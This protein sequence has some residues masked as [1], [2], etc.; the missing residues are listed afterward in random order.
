MRASLFSV[1]SIA[2]VISAY[3]LGG[4]VPTRIASPLD[5]KFLEELLS[6]MSSSMLVIA[7]FSLGT[8][9]TAYT[10]VSNSASPRASPVLVEGDFAQNAISTFIGVFLFS[11]IAQVALGSNVY[12]TGGRA[13]LFLTSLVLLLVSVATLINWID[14]LSR[15]GQ[16]R[17]TLKTLEQCTRTAI[18]ARAREPSFGGREF[19]SLPDGHDIC[20]K[21]F[22]YVQSVNFEAIEKVVDTQEGKFYLLAEPGT[23][24]HLHRPLGRLV[25]PYQGV[26][27][28]VADEVAEAFTVGDARTTLQDARFGL[29][30]IGEAAS[31][32]LSPGINDP[33]TA[34]DSAVTASRAICAW[35]EETLGADRELKRPWLYA[36]PLNITE[37]LDCAYAPIARYGS[38]Q[39]EVVI[40]LL[41]ILDGIAA[42]DLRYRQPARDF[43]DS[44]L[45]RAKL[46]I[47]FDSDWES[48]QKTHQSTQW[49]K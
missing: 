39:S 7:T 26:P 23:F 12:S 21:Q 48:I 34:I 19:E 30:I 31:R 16:V 43:S 8:M 1:A 49:L 36:N 29:L 13:L 2:I 17:E 14:E 27:R 44:M 15:L 22:G 37:L 28:D 3:L 35:H 40:R 47:S 32:A 45:A 20:A 25:G 11:V 24:V 46:H 33:G 41:K 5:S 6:I 4:F 38:S 42:L 18:V 9:V 10:A